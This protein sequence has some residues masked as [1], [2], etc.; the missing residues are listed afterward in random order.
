MEKLYFSTYYSYG[1]DSKYPKSIIVKKGEYDTGCAGGC[2]WFIT[3]EKVKGDVCVPYSGEEYVIIADN[4]SG[5][6]V[7]GK[8]MLKKH[9]KIFP[10]P[11]YDI[12]FTNTPKLP[13]EVGEIYE[14]VGILLIDV[15]RDLTIF[16]NENGNGYI[17]PHLGSSYT[18]NTGYEIDEYG[19]LWEM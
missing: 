13:K 4:E 18:S 12:A 1:E 7:E 14:D 10:G 11:T 6:F 2:R 17:T 3:T 5:S 8:K 19:N 9:H 15:E 16:I